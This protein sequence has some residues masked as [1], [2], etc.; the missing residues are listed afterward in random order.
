MVYSIL[1]LSC[2]LKAA[3]H[4]GLKLCSVIYFFPPF[5]VAALQKD[6]DYLYAT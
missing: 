5:F 4:L 1:H 3:L 2:R 6:R